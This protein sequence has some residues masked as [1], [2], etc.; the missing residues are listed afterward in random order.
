MLKNENDVGCVGEDEVRKREILK[1]GKYHNM[2][3]NTH[4]NLRRLEY[5]PK[6]EDNVWSHFP[7]I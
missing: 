1:M 4:F 6:T 5:C 7:K 3:S 2:V